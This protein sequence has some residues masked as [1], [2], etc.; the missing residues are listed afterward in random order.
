MSSIT[1]WNRWK[2]R[3]FFLVYFKGCQVNQTL[4]KPHENEKKLIWTFS[5]V[6]FNYKM[7]IDN[8]NANER[9]LKWE[10][11]I[12]KYND[13]LFRHGDNMGNNLKMITTIQ[14]CMELWITNWPS[15]W[16][17]C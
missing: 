12:N 16:W 9:T 6:V 7:A 3:L 2:G 8:N 1:C 4:Y 13:G 17:R 11:N 10:R 5:K 14:I 15:Y